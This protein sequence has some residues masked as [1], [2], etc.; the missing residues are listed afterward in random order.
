MEGSALLAAVLTS[1]DMAINQR[2]LGRASA[3]PLAAAPVLKPM[4]ATRLFVLGGIA[5]IAAGMI[6]G[7]IVA[8]FVLH[9]NAGRIGEHL[10][11]ATRAV[12]AQAP[13]AVLPH[14]T[15][16][17]HLLE[18]RGTKVDTHVH[19]IDFG[20]LALLLALV[21]PYVAL[22]E[23]RKR[24]LA[25]LFLT[26]AALLP[27][28]VFLIYYVGL[29]HGPLKAIGWASIL[30]D[31]GGLLVILACAGELV[32]LRRYQGGARALAGQEP[33]EDRSW[34]SRT[35]L[36]GGT[37]LVLAGFTHGA[38]Y[39]GA[40][41]YKQAAQDTALLRAMVDRAAGNHLEAATRAVGDYGALKGNEAVKIAAHAHLIEFG[42]LAMLLAFAQGY[43]F[44]SERWKR[45]WVAVLMAGSVVLPAFVL[46]E[47]KW[48]LV[49]GGI[50]DLGGLL[51]VIALIGML[52][53]ILRYTGVVD[54]GKEVTG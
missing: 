20:Y 46:L 44:L 3:A 16:I 40:D 24:W 31:F 4:S 29:A 22:S 50:A 25:Q 21:Q 41:L 39:A 26:G 48:G 18:N 9:Q 30:A 17:G 27:V 7:D 42:L 32:G 2:T 43:V 1:L 47:F 19:V 10:L 23:A 34:A 14:F 8:V 12:A 37:L 49:A 36:A 13:N 35:L 6:F 51:V 38:Y 15:A 45:R 53:G 11:A 54:A 52:V 28:S 33:L 5:L